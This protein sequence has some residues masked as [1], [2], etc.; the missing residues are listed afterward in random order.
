LPPLSVCRPRGVD[1]MNERVSL[2]DFIQKLIAQP[3]SKSRSLD[4]PCHIYQ[5]HGYQPG[6]VHARRILRVVDDAH[7]LVYA[8]RPEVGDPHVGLYRREGK[9]CDGDLAEGCCS[10]ERRFS[11][12]W[13]SDDSDEHNSAFRARCYNRIRKTGSAS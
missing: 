10:E 1:D 12:V 5:L 11:H 6:S 3:S 4:E 8:L 13:L 2:P 7:L 9:V